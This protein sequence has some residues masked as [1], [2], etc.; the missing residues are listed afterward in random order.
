MRTF[1]KVRSFTMFRSIFFFRA[2]VNFCY[3]LVISVQIKLLSLHCFYRSFVKPGPARP[4]HK[5][6]VK[7]SPN[8]VKSIFRLV[9]GLYGI[10]VSRVSLL[11]LGKASV[12]H[13][14]SCACVSVLQCYVF[15]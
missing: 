7:T 4:D 14:T 15:L 10:R 6:S 8:T 3:E 13:D 2:F 9:T 11:L 1:F 12:G 5:N